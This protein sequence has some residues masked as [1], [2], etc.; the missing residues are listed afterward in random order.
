M[1]ASINKKQQLGNVV[2]HSPCLFSGHVQRTFCCMWRLWCP[3]H[4]K[5]PSLGPR[6]PTQHRAAAC[7]DQQARVAYDKDC[8]CMG[9]WI[10]DTHVSADIDVWPS[11]LRPMEKCLVLP[12]GSQ[13]V[14]WDKYLE[15][16]QVSALKLCTGR[17]LASF[18]IHNLTCHQSQLL[19][20][21]FA[22]CTPDEPAFLI[23]HV[24]AGSS[25]LES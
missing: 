11:L 1:Q 20:F 3:T 2:L 14:W 22:Y 21:L 16:W 13:N 4:F 17:I 12:L 23:V 7:F 25:V 24:W 18:L 8:K 10:S 15:K 6:K 9:L 19:T 5:L